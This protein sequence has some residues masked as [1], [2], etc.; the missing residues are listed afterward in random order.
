MICAVVGVVVH[1]ILGYLLN[2]CIFSKPA[3]WRVLAEANMPELPE[4]ETTKR[5]IELHIVERQF[6]I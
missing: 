3:Y 2:H 6:P 5:G 1:E 4:V